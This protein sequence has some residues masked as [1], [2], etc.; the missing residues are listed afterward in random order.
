MNKLNIQRKKTELCLLAAMAAVVA[1]FAHSLSVPELFAD[2]D[3]LCGWLMTIITNSAGSQGLWLTV[4]VLSAIALYKHP[5]SR[6]EVCKRIVQLLVI[7][8]LG[9]LGKNAL[10]MLT[11][12]PRPYTELLTYELALP[13][14]QHFYKLNDQQRAQ[15]IEKVSDRV[16]SW[17]TRHWYQEMN[18]SLPSG[19]A[20]FAAICLV[21]FGSLFVRQQ[22]VV[23]AS[24]LVV[25][26][27]LVAYSRIWLGMHRPADVYGAIAFVGLLMLV[28]P[29]I[30][31][32]LIKKMPQHV[33]HQW[34]KVTH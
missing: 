9:Y 28:M 22:R 11:E 10:K 3:D 31:E 19:H 23:L 5:I 16:S 25:W 26:A 18:Y 21:F 15:V 20:V 1:P 29:S 24:L 33:K 4:L 12:S 2:V 27:A 17:R 6:S 30:E 34:L 32:W 7:F 8:L 14:P 13:N